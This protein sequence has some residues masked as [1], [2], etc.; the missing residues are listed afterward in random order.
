[1]R[2]QAAQRDEP[3]VRGD[4][5]TRQGGGLADQVLKGTARAYEAAKEKVESFTK[6]REK[7]PKGPGRKM[8]EREAAE[9]RED[10]EQALLGIW[11]FLDDGLALVTRGHKQPDIWRTIDDGDLKLIV[12]QKLRQ[13]QRSPKAAKQVYTTIDYFQRGAV[14]LIYGPRMWQS[15]QF[16]AEQG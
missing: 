16:L 2:D 5:E 14:Y 15:L 11:G 6:P 12:D 9:I 4:S 1:R 13:A 10:Y 7:A 8:S 3:D